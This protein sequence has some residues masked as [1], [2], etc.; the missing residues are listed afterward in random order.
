MTAQQ[1]RA[2]V[3]E[4]ARAATRSGKTGKARD[5]TDDAI[6][7]IRARFGST[8]GSDDPAGKGRFQIAKGKQDR[9][10]KTEIRGAV[11]DALAQAKLAST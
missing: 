7:T 4:A 9:R 2:M 11:E 8:P 10:L 3:D 1:A 5:F 6:A